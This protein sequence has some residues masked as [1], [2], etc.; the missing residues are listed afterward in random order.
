MIAWNDELSSSFMGTTHET[1]YLLNARKFSLKPIFNWVV[2][3]YIY[4][5]YT[6]SVSDFI[7][8]RLNG[9]SNKFNFL[10]WCQ[11]FSSINCTF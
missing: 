8:L 1:W 5:R 10:I 4:E 9:E 3:L 2:Q 7:V 6:S 11:I